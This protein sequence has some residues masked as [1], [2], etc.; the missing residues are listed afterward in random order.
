[1]LKFTLLGASSAALALAMIL[2]CQAAAPVKVG[3]VAAVADLVAEAD[4]KIKSIEESLASEES[5]NDAKKTKIPLDASILAVLAQAIAEHETAAAWK[6]GAPDVR[7]AAQALAKPTTFDDA[8]KSLATIKGAKEGK[9]AAAAVESPWGQLSRQGKVM[10]EVSKRNNKLRR[11]S[12]KLPDDTADAVRDASVLAILALTI[13][14]D[15]HEVK[16]AADKPEW[17]KYS[18][19]MQTASTDLAAALKAKN[20]KSVK[21]T[22]TRVSKSCADCHAKF[23]EGA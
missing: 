21:E 5:F 2:P 10:S 14:D 13:H 12:R 8:K 1:M 19:D 20:A 23:R 4:S 9:K 3:K 18:L 6:A 22:F 17:V 7:E 16:N 15:T 11:V